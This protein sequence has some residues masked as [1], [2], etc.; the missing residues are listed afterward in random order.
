[1]TPSFGFFGNSA[2]LPGTLTN[3]VDIVNGSNGNDGYQAQAVWLGYH[4]AGG[5]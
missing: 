4:H 3:L 1:M 5:L 2:T